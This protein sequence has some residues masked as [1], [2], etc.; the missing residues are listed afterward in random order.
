MSNGNYEARIVIDADMSKAMQSISKDLTNIANKSEKELKTNISKG[1]QKGTRQGETFAQQTLHRVKTALQ[2]R[3]S[4]GA[5][6]L[7]N[8]ALRDT[9]SNV[10]ELN[11]AQT[12]FRKVSDLSGANLDK[13]TDKASKLGRAVG[14][15][16]TEMIQAA[17]EFRK[18]SYGDEDALKLANIASLYQNVADGELSAGEAASFM[19]AQMKA[20]FSD[21]EDSAEGAQDAVDAINAVSNN[22]AVSSSDL[23]DNIGK[24]S[25]AM[26]TGNVTYAQTLGLMT[27]MTEVTRNAATSATSL[28]RIQSRFNQILDGSSSVGKK[29]TS[30]YESHG[31]DVYDKQTGQLRSMYDVLGDVSKQW[32]TLGENERKYFLLTQGSATQSNRLAALLNNYES[33]ANATST[34]EEAM[35]KNVS[36]TEEN[37]KYQ[38]SLAFA[39]QNLNA[40]WEQL[41][42]N[43]LKSDTLI[44]IV[45]LGTKILDIVNAL[46][47]KIGVMPTLLT[48]ITSVGLGGKL[49]KTNVFGSLLETV[50]KTTNGGEGA[51][52]VANIGSV[53]LSKFK[54]GIQA[55]NYKPNIAEL[56]KK[57]IEE[58][59]EAEVNLIDKSKALTKAKEAETVAAKKM[60]G[61][62]T[63]EKLMYAQSKKIKD[64]ASTDEV[65]KRIE[66]YDKAKRNARDAEIAYV[67]AVDAT[68]IA[69]KEM[70]E[71]TESARIAAGGFSP[72]LIGVVGAVAALL[73]MLGLKKLGD[74]FSVEGQ[75]E[76]Y[77]KLDDELSSINDR[78]KELKDKGD[79]RTPEEE[80]ELKLLELQS[81]Q[82]KR[83]L[84]YTKERIQLEFKQEAK[85]KFGQGLAADS[86]VDYSSIEASKLAERRRLE[87]E[88]NQAIE[89]GSIQRAKSIEREL[90]QISESYTET[91][92]EIVDLYDSLELIDYEN[93][94]DPSEKEYFKDIISGYLGVASSVD[95]YRNALDKLPKNAQVDVSAVDV[96]GNL[97]TVSYTVDQLRSMS[98]EEIQLLM[99]AQQTGDWSEI[100]KWQ[101]EHPEGS[102]TF[103]DFVV[104]FTTKG[105]KSVEQREEELSEQ[106]DA[107]FQAKLNNGKSVEN[108]TT[109]LARDRTIDFFINLPNI[110]SARN[111]VQGLAANAQGH[112][113]TGKSKGAPGGTAWLGD[114]GTAQNPKPE[115]VVGEHGAYLAGTK[116]W[117][118]Y[119]LKS[120]DTVYTY[121]QTKKLLGGSQKF[122]SNGEIPRFAKGTTK[123]K[124]SAFDKALA[125]LEYKRDVYHWT[126]SEFQKQYNS[127]YKKYK[128]YLSTDQKRAYNKSLADVRH[129]VAKSDIDALI[130]V[131]AESG[132]VQNALN[133]I[134]QA[135]NAQRIS[136]DEYKEMR[137]EAYKNAL[138]YTAKEYEAGR[139]SYTDLLKV[140]KDYWKEVGKDS[141]EYYESLDKMRQAQQKRLETKQE[142]HEDELDYAKQYIQ[143][144]INSLERQKEA[145]EQQKEAV[146]DAQELVDLQNDLAQA[147]STMVKVYREGVG[148]VYEQDTKAVRDAQRALDDFNAEH[149]TDEVGALIKQYERIL[150]L[151][152]T[153][154]EEADFIALGQKLG[155]SGIKDIIK[156]SIL[157]VDYMSN[158]IK[159]EHTWINALDDWITQL[160]NMSA[161][162]Y[163][164]YALT[165][166]TNDMLKDTYSRYNYSYDDIYGTSKRTLAFRQT[167]SAAVAKAKE[168]ALL[169]R[170]NT[171][172]Q[173][174]SGQSAIQNFNFKELVL[175]AV[176]NAQE[177][178]AEL[179]KLPNMAI[180]A[181]AQR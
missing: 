90:N 163:K 54:A 126:D 98:D 143:L 142:K 107:V 16:G 118:L 181:S 88:Y 156:G 171:A 108:E 61:Q 70:A 62:Q 154:G 2:Q 123:K 174:V 63:Y 4:Y 51:D 168:I 127:L 67:E 10:K 97:R 115:L 32:N 161:E 114:E 33:V 152:D 5:I 55:R 109:K 139:K 113:A 101:S 65:I 157:D 7:F 50:T 48:A 179:Q 162:M 27:G 89:E 43:I 40:A 31:I 29:L 34:A 176:K 158:W 78:I 30:W 3:I 173:T 132:D 180:Q 57:S 122:T 106:R 92:Q 155:I 42:N 140:A 134:K 178:V 128:K 120:S 167:A 79:E 53:L 76:H 37:A 38:E 20:G 104:E 124:R 64:D 12:E 39:L 45:N 136:S 150:E 21:I 137:K 129:D 66:R 85:A 8:R 22:F 133:R 69:E 72:V 99:N 19:I 172:I 153:F 135:R 18:S 23:A 151:F 91:Y 59:T 41:S 11:S 35:E 49:L 94:T 111:K 93:L 9:I 71:A 144:Q 159:G 131:I 96:N 56:E 83:Q 166:I 25:A 36:A 125:T 28:N 82:Y 110:A 147:R 112:Y 86:K 141:K 160:D 15:T 6:D 177:F 24:T 87:A 170:D 47:E 105:D 84:D 17:T 103:N 52:E 60:I 75:T 121:A 46:V 145:N 165:G 116:G 58:L 100:E 149:T 13:Y 164:T 102:E 95:D 1:I 146:E 68:T 44:N 175:P 77:H 119:N 169:S 26:A 80:R 138:D 130:D 73:A 117:E 14:R 81:E 74:Y 148:W